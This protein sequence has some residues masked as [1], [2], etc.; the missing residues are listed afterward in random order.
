MKPYWGFCTQLSRQAHGGEFANFIVVLCTWLEFVRWLY[1]MNSRY[2]L[3]IL[4][5]TLRFYDK[6][7]INLRY[8]KYK[9]PSCQEGRKA[10]YFC[11]NKNSIKNDSHFIYSRFLTTECSCNVLWLAEHVETGWDSDHCGS[12]GALQR[13]QKHATATSRNF[14]PDTQKLSLGLANLHV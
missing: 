12:W 8:E 13:R 7:N 4:K 5:P 14:T 11:H 9:A 1:E 6:S 3:P 10:N 2:T